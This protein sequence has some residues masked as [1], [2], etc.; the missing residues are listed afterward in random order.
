[1]MHSLYFYLMGLCFALPL[2][3]ASLHLPPH[4]RFFSHWHCVGIKSQI[5][6][7]KPLAVQV[8]DLPLVLW[9]DPQ[10]RI[11]STI[12][13]CKH[14]G[15]TLDKGK[16]TPTGC[17]KCPYHGLEM[18]KEDSFG[19]VVEDDGK[20]FWSYLPE[21][22]RPPAVPFA[23]LPAKKKPVEGSHNPRTS[24][25]VTSHLVIDMDTSLPDSAYNTM[26]LRHPEFVHG[27]MFGFGSGIP[28]MNLQHYF[29]GQS[30]DNGQG[31]GQCTKP[32]HNQFGLSFNYKANVLINKINQN[33]GTTHNFHMYVYPTF[34]WSKVTVDKTKHLLIG[35]HLLPIG[36]NKTR[37]FITIR[38]N[39]YTSN[40]GQRL[41]QLLASTI[42]QQDWIQMRLQSRETELKRAVTFGYTFPEEDA[43]LL[44]KDWFRDYKYPAMSTCAELV[45]FDRAKSSE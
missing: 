41:M 28:P 24:D 37:W 11:Y 33:E 38:H 5:N 1:M 9:R 26:D 18:S 15:S 20:L 32:K 29:Y 17:L 25:Y 30:Q 39:Y 43:I 36:P 10:N 31:Q 42:L 35:V 8:G 13:I 16:I 40:S 4:L 45:R 21:T 3:I 22:S 2:P 19:T 14:M 7:A 23:P 34:S 12:N 44:L 27:N 6:F